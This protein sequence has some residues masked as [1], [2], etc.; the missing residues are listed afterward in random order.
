MVEMIEMLPLVVVSLCLKR[1]IS[2][3]AVASVVLKCCDLFSGAHRSLA[4]QS[5][6]KK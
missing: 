4:K 2:Q 3:K 1:V 5:L 6:N